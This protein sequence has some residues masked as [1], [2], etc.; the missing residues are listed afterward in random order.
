LYKTF[1]APDPSFKFITFDY[2][3]TVFACTTAKLV[4]ARKKL[5]DT[6]SHKIIMFVYKAEHAEKRDPK[7]LSDI[8]SYAASH[9]ARHL[10]NH[11]E[12]AEQVIRETYNCLCCTR[13]QHS[14]AIFDVTTG[15][16][17]VA[18]NPALFILHLNGYSFHREQPFPE[19][20]VF[21]TCACRH[22]GRH[23]LRIYLE[24]NEEYDYVQM[25][26]R[27]LGLYDAPDDYAH[28]QEYEAWDQ[29]QNQEQAE[30]AEQIEA[31]AMEQPEQPE[32]D[33]LYNDAELAYWGEERP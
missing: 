21:C 30:L 23:A 24:I 19:Q 15:H 17:T 13:H 16:P 12:Y 25:R 1:L 33:I 26:D 29:Q 18:H 9:A 32:V 7:L 2:I 14:K 28:A 27:R 22:L 3:M 8:R 5:P 6:I 11:P 31:Q 4:F 10:D 20:G